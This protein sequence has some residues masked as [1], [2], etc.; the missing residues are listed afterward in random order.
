MAACTPTKG[1]SL[2]PSENHTS[3]PTSDTSN[4]IFF[5][6]QEKND[7]E[8]AVLDGEIHGTL[9]LADNCIRVDHDYSDTSYLLI[10]PP[11]F[12][13]TIENGT[14]KILTERII[15]WHLLEIG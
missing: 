7:G 14:I 3:T 13:M 1:A 6:R 4:T 11:D 8:R 5:P 15:S 10:W 9:V 12:N 2:Q